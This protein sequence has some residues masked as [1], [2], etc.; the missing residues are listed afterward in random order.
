VHDADINGAS[1][2]FLRV[3]VVFD[4][5]TEMSLLVLILKK[6]IAAL[7]VSILL[8]SFLG[9]SHIGMTMDKEGHMTHCPFM[10]GMSMCM[11]TPMEMVAASHSFLSNFA[12]GESQLTLLL[13]IAAA[14]VVSNFASLVSPPKISSQH[15]LPKRKL[16]LRHSFLDEAFSAGI[17]N[18]KLF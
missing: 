17:L 4:T 7:L 3:T 15:R 12:L 5:I 9:V 2:K 13:L 10:P 6:S 11:M 8:A 16:R 18:P 14:L 1:A